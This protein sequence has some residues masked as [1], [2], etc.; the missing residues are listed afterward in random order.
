MIKTMLVKKHPERN[1]WDLSQFSVISVES[2]FFYSVSLS[3]QENLEKIF[4]ESFNWKLFQIYE[5]IL[6]GCEVWM[7][8]I[9]WS[10]TYCAC[11]YLCFFFFSG[12]SFSRL[13]WKLCGSEAILL[14]IQ[15]L[16]S[17]TSGLAGPLYYT[18]Q[19]SLVEQLSIPDELQKISYPPFF[20]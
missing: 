11:V 20:V 19:I 17:N 12:V 9:L 13:F 15:S 5:V 2:L 3:L 8:G 4:C 10:K 1:Q 16:P 6:W 14:S 18:V 7:V